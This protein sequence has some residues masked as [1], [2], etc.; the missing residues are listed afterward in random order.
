M[1]DRGDPNAARG[2]SIKC[3]K[4]ALNPRVNRDPNTV[5]NNQAMQ[6]KSKV[7]KYRLEKK[8]ERQGYKDK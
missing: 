2:R 5:G 1:I 4:Q 8:L 6:T 3:I 7:Q